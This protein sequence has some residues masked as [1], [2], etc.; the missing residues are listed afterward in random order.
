MN[1]DSHYIELL[2]IHLIQHDEVQQEK[3]IVVHY[4]G[5]NKQTLK[6]LPN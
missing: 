5:F 6:E 1:K 2:E 4:N 3:N